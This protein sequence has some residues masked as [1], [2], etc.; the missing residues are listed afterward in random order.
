MVTTR[1]NGCNNVPETTN[2]KAEITIINNKKAS[3]LQRV[4]RVEAQK[5]ES[6]N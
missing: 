3:R 6:F 1:W 4:S 2:K 5:D